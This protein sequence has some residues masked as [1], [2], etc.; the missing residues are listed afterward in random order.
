MAK[1]EPESVFTQI[2]FSE[3]ESKLLDRKTML[4]AEITKIIR[5]RGYTQKQLSEILEQPQPRI[6]E[7]FNCKIQHISIEKLIDY[8]ER[9][10]AKVSLQITYEDTGS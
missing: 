4:L 6:S 8:L 10:G 5:K 7:L 1:N 9:L 2:G 3:E